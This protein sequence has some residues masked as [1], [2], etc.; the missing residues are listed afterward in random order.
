MGIDHSHEQSVKLI[1]SNTGI[2]NIFDS[3]DAMYAHIMALPEKLKAIAQFEEFTNVLGTQDSDAVEH[4]E[5]SL[6]FQKRFG[7]D[8]KAV[9]N[10]LKKTGNPFLPE[11]G[12]RLKSYGQHGDV[13]D[14]D[15]A[16]QLCDAQNIGKLRHGTYTD[17]RLVRCV[18]PITDI[19]NKIQLPLFSN[20][21]ELKNKK[22]SESNQT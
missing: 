11:S 3:K 10:E 20:H 22:Q 5:E 4:H 12:P 6:A 8:V 7:K 18:K 21:L 17:E 16:K 14:D 2:G 1:K 13:M 9:Y 19:I 15:Q